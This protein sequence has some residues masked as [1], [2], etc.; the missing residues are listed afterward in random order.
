MKKIPKEAEENHHSAHKEPSFLNIV[1]KFF[2]ASTSLTPG[3]PAPF[4]DTAPDSETIHQD[5]TVPDHNHH[6]PIVEHSHHTHDYPISSSAADVEEIKPP[7]TNYGSPFEKA[8]NFLNIEAAESKEPTAEILKPQDMKIPVRETVVASN[9]SEKPKVAHTQPT[10]DEVRTLPSAFSS[11]ADSFPGHVTANDNPSLTSDLSYDPYAT[12]LGEQTLPNTNFASF[13]NSGGSTNYDDLKLLAPPPKNQFSMMGDSSFDS[14]IYPPYPPH[15]NAYH[16]NV[17][18]F[19]QKRPSFGKSRPSRA[20]TGPK[21][22][23][24]EVVRSI[25]FELGPNG[26]KRL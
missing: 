18:S 19:S 3:Y 20:K 10:Y 4:G 15:F 7:S 2:S 1:G 25:A 12:F 9:E 16:D 24:Y 6:P 13:P 21:R 22:N 5:H 14:P 17:P 23:P 26:P 8:P 11:N